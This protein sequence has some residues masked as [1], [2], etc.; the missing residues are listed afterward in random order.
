M[1]YR[2]VPLESWPGDRTR[3]RKRSPFK[4]RWSRTV[5]DLDR[6]LRHLSARNVVIQADC[7]RSEIRLDGFLRADA[8][9]RGPGVVLTFDSR[10]GPL[11]YPCD[12]F[13]DWQD[14]VRAI[15]L[16]LEALR[17]V[18][19]YGVTRQAEQYKGWARLAAPGSAEFSSL[20]Q[21][22]TF[23]AQ[24]AGDGTH[25][26]HV[27]QVREIFQKAYR[28]AAGKLHPDANGGQDAAFKRLQA[29]KSVLERHHG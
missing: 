12:T 13:T 26:E 15:A 21:A 8:R 10:H 27:L 4:S 11:S 7:E 23:V 18:N 14:N 6:E 2:F 1:E 5:D 20:E 17:A 29:A 16:A 28:Q 3:N 9:L 22:A 25:F 19:R 24:H